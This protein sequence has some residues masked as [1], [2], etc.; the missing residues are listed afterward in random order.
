M[1]HGFSPSRCESFIE[2]LSANDPA[3]VASSSFVL[4]LVS[5][6]GITGSDFIELDERPGQFDSRY[7]RHGWFRALRITRNGDTAEDLFERLAANNQKES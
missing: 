5:E 2:Q 4:A 6:V 7:D 3:Y 1:S